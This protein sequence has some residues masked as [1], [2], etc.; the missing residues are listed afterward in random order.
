M[1]DNPTWDDLR[2]VP[3][4]PG[5]GAT[6]RRR[7]TQHRPYL[8]QARLADAVGANHSSIARLESGGRAPSR[9]MA[10]ALCDALGLAGAERYELLGLAGY[11]PL[12]MTPELA[13]IL[14]AIAA[15]AID[16]DKA[17]A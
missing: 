3:A 8:S 4:A 7:R 16:G 17:A 5:F 1:S 9:A 11:C 13:R 6:L 14:A 2:L 10:D 15:C 12:P